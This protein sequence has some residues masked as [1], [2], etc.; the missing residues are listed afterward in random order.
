MKRLLIV[1]LML[2]LLVGC[3][4][5]EIIPTEVPTEPTE[6][7]IPWVE[8]VGMD[9]DTEGVLKEIPLTIP[10]GLHLTSIMNFDGDL[11]LWSIDDHL[12]QSSLEMVLVELDDGTVTATRDIP[13]GQYVYPQCLGDKL[14]LC[15][16]TTG[17]VMAL[18]KNLE[19]VQQWEIEPTEY[20]LNIG[21]NGVLYASTTD[22]K[23]LAG[24][25]GRSYH[26]LGQPRRR[27][28]DRP[29]LYPRHRH[30]GLCGH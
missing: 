24:A 29:L 23:L 26:R 25:G 1:L 21:G 8:E 15:D 27:Q 13:V 17:L 10:D 7:P 16:G 12:A 14:Y 6:P 9:W 3:S 28:H 19:T 11:L 30:P 22:E 20:S 5:E 18:D 4:Q 2:L